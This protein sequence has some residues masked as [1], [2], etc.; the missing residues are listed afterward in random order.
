[1]TGAGRGI[2]R[3]IA[4]TLTLAATLAITQSAETGLPV[5]IDEMIG[6]R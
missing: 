2:G 4:E 1:M 5:R 3:G 6:R